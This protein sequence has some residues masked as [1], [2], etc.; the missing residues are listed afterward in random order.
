MEKPP[1]NRR[2]DPAVCMVVG[3]EKKAL[4]R[5]AQS[6]AAIKTQRGYCRD[7]KALANVPE[8]T[9]ESHAEWAGRVF[10]E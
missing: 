9:R 8:R 6:V 5:N 2:A 4:Y 7:H 1:I 10:N 3:C